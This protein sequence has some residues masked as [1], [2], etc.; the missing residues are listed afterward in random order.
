MKSRLYLLLFLILVACSDPLSH[1]VIPSIPAGQSHPDISAKV[2]ADDGFKAALSATAVGDNLLS[3]PGFEFALTAWGTC[4]NGL[5][6]SSDAKTGTGAADLKGDCFYQSVDLSAVQGFSVGQDVSLSCQV[7]VVDATGWAG[8]GL[9]FANDTWQP[10][11]SAP[12][13]VLSGSQYRSYITTFKAPAGVRYASI[14]AYTDGHIRLDDCELFIGQPPLP[15]GNLLLNASF[16]DGKTY[17]EN[18][19][20]ASAYSVAN[21]QLNI[22]GTACIYQVANAEPPKLSA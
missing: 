7:K 1:P 13:Q 11:A 21:G 5:S 22:S 14:W 19:G 15:Q 10:I 4:G 18:C 12:T 8:L 6:H 16:D 3:N 20:D 9:S 17:W 2:F